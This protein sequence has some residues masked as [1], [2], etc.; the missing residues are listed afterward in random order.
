MI[1]EFSATYHCVTQYSWPLREQ[2]E[3]I[4]YDHSMQ[5]DWQLDRVLQKDPISSPVNQ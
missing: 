5:I 1:G 4:V 2:K 3:Q